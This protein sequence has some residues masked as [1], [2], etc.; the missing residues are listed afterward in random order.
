LAS[1]IIRQGNFAPLFCP[2]FPFQ[3]LRTPRAP[4]AGAEQSPRDNAADLSR[5]SG[6]RENFDIARNFMSVLLIVGVVARKKL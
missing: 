2:A 1:F 4:H 6:D 5:D 3:R